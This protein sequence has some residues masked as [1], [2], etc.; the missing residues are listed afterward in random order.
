[1]IFN[2]ILDV[3]KEHVQAEFHQ[4]KCS[5]LRIIVLRKKLATCSNNSAVTTAAVKK[6]IQSAIW[7]LLLLSLLLPNEWNSAVVSRGKES[8][9]DKVE[10]I[11]VWEEI[12]HVLLSPQRITA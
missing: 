5:G 12:F 6:Q 3:I 1:L 7:L 11:V 9:V 2:K 4:A 10:L 8:A